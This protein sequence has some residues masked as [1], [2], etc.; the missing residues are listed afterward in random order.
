[1]V[2]TGMWSRSGGWIRIF[3][4]GVAITNARPL[5]SERYGYRRVLRI[6][7]WGVSLLGVTPLHSKARGRCFRASL[8]TR[9]NMAH[10]IK[11]NSRGDVKLCMVVGCG[12]KGLYRKAGNGAER[13]Y[14]SAHK[15]LAISAINYE[16]V[17]AH[18]EY[19]R[20]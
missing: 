9:C 11:I 10:E 15:H 3:G 5:F 13:G 17:E 16:S 6:W 1:M 7:G 19:R 2:I 18:E 4:Y 20:K 8:S 14:C 12:R